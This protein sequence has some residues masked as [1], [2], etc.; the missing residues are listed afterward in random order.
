M[1]HLSVNK[2]PHQERY[3][4]LREC[5]NNDYFLEEIFYSARIIH[6]RSILPSSVSLYDCCDIDEHMK[7]ACVGKTLGKRAFTSEVEFEDSRLK[8][9]SISRSQ[10]FSSVEEGPRSSSY[11]TSARG[12][13]GLPD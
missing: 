8:S 6:R 13:Y 10:L 1:L 9:S 3:P 12:L 4:P 5:Q 7:T 11:T 2:V